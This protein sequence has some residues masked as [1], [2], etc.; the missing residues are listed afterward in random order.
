MLLQSTNTV[1]KTIINWTHLSNGIQGA[2]NW[3][4]RH[5]HN[6][7]SIVIVFIC[8]PEYN[9]KQLENVKWVENLKNKIFKS[10]WTRYLKPYRFK[11][12]CNLMSVDGCIY[13]WNH[14]CRQD[15]ERFHCS[16][17]LFPF[18]VHLPPYLPPGNQGS[19][20]G[21]VCILYK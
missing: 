5:N 16:Q 12:V 9:T 1:V 11:K 8:A 6:G 4:Y 10:N 3:Y 20:F 21:L 14:H 7:Y 15:A 18:A 2:Y 17:H 19:F 13:P